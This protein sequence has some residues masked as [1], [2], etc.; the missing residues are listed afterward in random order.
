LESIFIGFDPLRMIIVNDIQE[1][2]T[3]NIIKSRYFANNGEVFVNEIATLVSQNA[4]N[5]GPQE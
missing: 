1:L 5:D 2:E 3:I 4:E